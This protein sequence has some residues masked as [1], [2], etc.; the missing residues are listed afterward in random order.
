MC[1]TKLIHPQMEEIRLT[2]RQFADFSKKRGCWGEME[3]DPE[4]KAR[5]W[6]RGLKCPVEPPKT[7]YSAKNPQRKFQNSGGARQLRG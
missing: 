3:Q 6:K 5:T 2:V 7:Q 4:H 1:C